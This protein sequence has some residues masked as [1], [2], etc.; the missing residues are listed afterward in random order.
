MSDTPQPTTSPNPYQTPAD[1]EP[2]E[3]SPDDPRLAEL[4]RLF[5]RW[6]KLRLIYNGILAAV[7][8]LCL[9]VVY[10]EGAMNVL[11]LG[12]LAV[13]C[14]GAN[15]CYLAGPAVDGY[16]TWFGLRHHGITLILFVSGT[17]LSMALAVFTMANISTGGPP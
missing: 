7:V 5:V 16:L 13:A 2:L 15:V 4:G 9:P 1:T 8:L 12:E 3:T 11:F 6:E 14:L 10:L 17:L